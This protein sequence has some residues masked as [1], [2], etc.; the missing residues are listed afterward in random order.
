MIRNRLMWGTM[1]IL[2]GRQS[3]GRK[4]AVGSVAAATA[5]GL[6]LLTTAPGSAD[7][8]N[9]NEDAEAYGQLIDADILTADAVDAL[10]AYSSSPS[11]TAEDSTPI[12]A[13][14]LQ[15]I[16]VELPGIGIPLISDEDGDGLLEL[17]E[18]GALNAYG[19]APAYNDATAS[20]GAVG[21]DGGLNL[22]DINNGEYGNA[23]VDLTSVLVQLNLDGVTDEIVDELSL[24][25][26]AIASTANSDGTADDSEYA[27]ADGILT[28]SSPAVG[29][30]SGALDEVVDGAGGTLEDVIGEEGLVN[31][32]AGVGVN[33]LNVLGLAELNVGGDD[34]TVSVEVR[35]ALNSVVENVVNEALEDEAGIVSID[36]ANGDIQID[37]AKIV[38]GGDAS[39]LN[40]LDP[41]TQ[42]LTSDTI[43]QIT[44]PVADAIGALS[45]Q[46]NDTLTDAL[47]DVHLVIELPASIELLSG[48]LPGVNGKIT[49]D[50]T[51]GQLAGTDDTDPDIDTDLSILGVDAG[52]II[53][54]VTDP[55]VTSLLSITEPLIGGILDSTADEVAG[56]VT[57]IVDPVLTSLDPVFGAL[58][59]VVD[60]TINEQPTAKDPAEES[61]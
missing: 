9:P 60:L 51:L 10:S 43:S 17:G 4:I 37:L 49:V 52:A 50:A 44:G 2:R 14:V 40:G 22:D 54:A 21:E 55:L 8:Q 53:N 11:N 3:T 46:V 12:N 38:K 18:G 34:T 48:T 13:E 24:E 57:D 45:G 31:D 35:D 32:L 29:D 56:A 39:D 27:V 26:G 59:Q 1:K 36:L 41:N 15:A 61:Q 25:L 5:V 58:N 28:V 30:L 47:N 20:S 7:E 19:H 42:V 16:G 6:T 33:D 23:H